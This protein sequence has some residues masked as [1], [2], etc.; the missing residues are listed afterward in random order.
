M[1]GTD[2][3]KASANVTAFLRLRSRRLVSETTEV[4]EKATQIQIDFLRNELD[5]ARAFASR[6]LATRDPDTR[7][8]NQASARKAYE[9]FKRILGKVSVNPAQAADL[10]I[11]LERLRADFNQLEEQS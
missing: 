9:T 1:D 8:R 6:A 11:Q 4:I 2:M 5:I 10:F 7:A 3:P